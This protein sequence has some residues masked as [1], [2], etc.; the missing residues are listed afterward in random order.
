MPRLTAKMGDK[1]YD[2]KRDMGKKEEKGQEDVLRRRIA[3]RRK[4]R[5][6]RR[7]QE[8]HDLEEEVVNRKMKRRKLNE[9]GG[10]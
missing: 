4:I 7:G 2:E 5:S 1:D 10:Y 8:M 9:D 3:R 6:K